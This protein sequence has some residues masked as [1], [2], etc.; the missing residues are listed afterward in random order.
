M[1]SGRGYMGAKKTVMAIMG[2]V[3]VLLE[4]IKPT[5]YQ[6]FSFFSKSSPSL[7]LFCFAFFPPESPVNGT[8]AD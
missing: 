4:K 2:Q 8:W 6:H 7:S 1:S 5:A 3:Q